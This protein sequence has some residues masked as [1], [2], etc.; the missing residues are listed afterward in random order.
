MSNDFGMVVKTPGGP[1]VLQWSALP[2]VELAPA[3]VRIAQRAVGVNFLDTYYR[4]GAYP[5]PST[6]LIPGGEAAG[7][8]EEIGK[9]V[10][11]LKVGDR[12]AYVLPVGA[13]RQHRIAPAE[14]VVK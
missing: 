12:V 7:V 5:W 3:E 9:E 6:P 10:T 8:I 14:R 2:H 11:S 1:E 4:K 13:Y